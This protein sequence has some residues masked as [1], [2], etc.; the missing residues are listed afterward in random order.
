MHAQQ[1]I[2]EA[3]RAGLLGAT[4]AGDRVYLDRVRAL[5]ATQLPAILI[6]EHEQ[7]EEV[8]PPVAGRAE[9]RRLRV[10]LRAVVADVDEA[11][12][13]ARA[14]GLQIERVLG[15]PSFKA[16]KANR[17]RLLA[18]RH[19]PFDGGEVPMSAREQLWAV[20]YFLLRREAPDQP[21]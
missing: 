15:A 3:L 4:D 13:K 17:V 5:D 19:M 10:L 18:S 7:G 8:D 14:L 16:I 11:P 21:S 2:L 20:T 9:Q 12:G 1:Q 6:R